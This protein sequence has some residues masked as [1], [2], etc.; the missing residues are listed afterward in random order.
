MSGKSVFGLDVNVVAA[1]AYAA[2]LL[3]ALVT[4]TYAVAIFAPVVLYIME[5]EN[6]FVRF[7]SLQSS[8]VAL[9]FFVV[10]SLL[11]LIPLLG[12][13]AQIALSCVL[14]TVYAIMAY[15]AYRGKATKLPFVGEPVWNQIYK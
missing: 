12:W 15:N 7:H 13:I 14:I 5:R 4:N 1:L 9:V 11:G 3:I 8:V 10:R 6:Q 2:V